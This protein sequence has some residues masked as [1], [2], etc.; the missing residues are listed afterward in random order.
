[1]IEP[2]VVET[3][4]RLLVQ[5]RLP[6][7]EVARRLGVSRGTVHAIAQGKRP[8]CPAREEP[9]DFHWS[10]GPPRRCPGCGGMVRMPCLLCYLR[11]RNPG[12]N[13]HAVA[14][15]DVLPIG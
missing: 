5:Q 12:E 2:T 7:R 9:V 15:A 6:Q 4:R 8:D 10:L 1:M 3:I 14:E 13:A 11:A